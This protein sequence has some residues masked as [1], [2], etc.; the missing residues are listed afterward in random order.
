MLIA[1]QLHS[2]VRW[3]RRSTEG[4]EEAEKSGGGEESMAQTD[5]EE[6]QMVHQHV[7]IVSLV[8]LFSVG[9]SAPVA[10]L[11]SNINLPF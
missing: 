10:I 3:V 4:D 9:N 5:T 6:A 8:G 1:L 2:K 7:T 11:P